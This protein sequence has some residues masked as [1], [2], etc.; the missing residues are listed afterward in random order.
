[1]AV[2]AVVAGA[3]VGMAFL[4]RLCGGESRPRCYAILTDFLSRLCGGEYTS[5]HRYQ[6]MP[7]LSRLCG[8]ES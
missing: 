3:W 1:M 4:S 6:A 8:G 7:F 2:N 5:N